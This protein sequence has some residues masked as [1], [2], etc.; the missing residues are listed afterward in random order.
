[1][2]KAF[3]VIL[4]SP[5]MLILFLLTF[6]SIK[7]SPTYVYRLIK[8]NVADVYDYKN[9]EN[10]DIKGAKSFYSFEIKNEET[11]I[12]SLLNDRVS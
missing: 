11:Y 6:L 7:Y 3:K 1:M 2:K 8:M 4:L 5:L 9:F 12:E 10:R